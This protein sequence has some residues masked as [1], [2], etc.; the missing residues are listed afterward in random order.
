[1]SV[2]TLGNK[3]IMT[4]SQYK[5]NVKS[6]QVQLIPI[7]EN[8]LD[9]LNDEIVGLIQEQLSEGERGDGSRLP[10]YKESTK[11]IKK[12]RG[13]ILMGERIALIDT[14]RFWDSM[15]SNIYKESI[16]VDSKDWKRDML[17][18]QYGN[19][20][21]LISEKQMSYLADLVRP[22]FFAKVNEILAS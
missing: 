11:L 2:M 5:N 13:T 4:V 20:I 12:E 15:F 7:V 18:E 14:G 6:L 9:D 10:L 17:V 16:M 3:P 8:I 19:E 22:H 1:M 21:F